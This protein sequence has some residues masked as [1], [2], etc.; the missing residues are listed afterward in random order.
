[1]SGRYVNLKIIESGDRLEVYKYS[2]AYEKGKPTNNENGRKGK[3]RKAPNK[4]KNRRETLIKARNNIIRLVNCNPDLLTFITFTYKENMQEI[5]QSKADLKKC[6]KRLQKDCEDFKYLYVTEFQKRG[7]IHYHMICSF[8]VPL[9]TAKTKEKKP[10]K[11]KL[12]ERQFSD[13]Y[14]KYGF[15]DIRSL[16]GNTNVGLYVAVYLV[17]DLFNID[18]KGAKCYGYSRNLNKPKER[19]ILT[20]MKPYEVAQTF[21][22]YNL[23]YSSSY[24]MKYEVEKEQITNRVN[25]FDFYR[26]VVSIE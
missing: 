26:E 5:T 19:A 24:E 8:N 7:A 4:E 20:Y 13:K 23:K 2:R 18:L 3:G 9:I 15:V 25:Y 11:Q 17:E 12:F 14:W 21:A 6:I 10:E 16:E 1:M 22:E